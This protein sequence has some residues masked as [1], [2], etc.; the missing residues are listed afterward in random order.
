MASLDDL[1]DNSTNNNVQA[2]NNNIMIVVFI[3]GIII[4]ILSLILYIIYLKQDKDTNV[5]EINNEV[6]N[7]SID[8]LVDISGA[9]E[10]PGVYSLKEN[11]RMNQLLIMAGGFSEDANKEWVQK[12]LNLASKLKDGQKIYIPFENE[13]VST[14]SESVQGASSGLLININTDNK[15]ELE[16][17]PKIGSVTAQNIIDYRKSNGNFQDITDIKK[18]PGIG[19]STF[20]QIKDL[21]TIE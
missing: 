6:I 21:I 14:G 8:I 9:V 13:N 19:D 20:F 3:I 2:K 18:V 16:N 10:K 4:S 12:S 1:L 5:I 11:D 15:S 17:L 7:N